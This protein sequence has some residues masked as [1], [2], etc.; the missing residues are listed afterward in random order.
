MADKKISALTGATTPLAGTEV[1]PIVQTSATVKVAVSD[2]T[3]GRIVG[4][5]SFVPSSSTVATN[6]MYLP[7]AN[8]LGLSTNSTEQMR[9]TSAGLVGINTANTTSPVAP[10][11]RL[12]V[13]AENIAIGVTGL[14]AAQG[15]AFVGTSTAWAPDVGGTL[16]LGG[17]QNSGVLTATY[18]SVAGRRE[19]ALGYIYAGYMQFGV[20]DGANV[21]ERMRIN[22]SGIVTMGAYGAGAATFSAAGVISSVS[23]ETWKTKDGVPTN[24][25]AMLQ[26]LEPGYWFY[27]KEK[28]LIFGQDRQLGF[29]AQNVHDAIGEE[30]A[31]IP[32]TY[33]TKDENG[34]ETSVNK[35]WGYYDRSVL[36]V[37]VMSLKNAL[38]T[39]EELKQRIEV[40]ENK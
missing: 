27:N 26:K 39:I 14:D 21:V 29:Y 37:A 40:L 6:G 3:A 32:E 9:I 19:S 12:D 2:L 35:P 1:L 31:P 23:D 34:N 38:A 10:Q 13:R 11:A 4:A 5:S 25:D 22:S 7:A 16:A 28:A 24:P 15:Q 17:T 20:N 30:A 33:T 18:A 36:A 8:S